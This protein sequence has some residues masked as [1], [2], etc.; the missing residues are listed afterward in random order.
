MTLRPKS[1]S[2]RSGLVFL[3]DGEMQA[4]DGPNMTNAT[5]TGTLVQNE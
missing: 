4:S 3:E 1:D 5:I 2:G